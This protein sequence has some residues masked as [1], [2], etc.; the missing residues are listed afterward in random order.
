ME[1]I[2]NDTVDLYAINK[3]KNLVKIVLDHWKV[4]S[5]KNT[6]KVHSVLNKIALWDGD[7]AGDIEE[8][9]Y[10]AMWE[11]FIFRNILKAQIPD[12]E[13]KMKIAS[14]AFFEQFEIWL[15]RN[16]AA[17]PDFKHEI[18]GLYNGE[19]ING[20]SELIVRAFEQAVE[21]VSH[22]E[23]KGEAINWSSFIEFKYKSTPFTNTF[24][25]PVFDRSVP[26]HGSRNTGKK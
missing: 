7:F 5:H 18:C 8:P 3:K 2:L 19:F 4:H 10:F 11:L 13:V 17:N 20:C 26:G 14:N 1:K 9:S 15:F 6:Q 21:Y 22:R 24:L 16:V 23:S 12:E 25:A